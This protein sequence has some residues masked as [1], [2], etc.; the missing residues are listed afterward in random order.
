MLL[1]TF[2]FG[3]GNTVFFFKQGNVQIY[4]YFILIESSG[5]YDW[6]NICSKR[7]QPASARHG[8]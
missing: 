1:H 3:S 4:V 7:S 2:F 6:W 8:H 5:H